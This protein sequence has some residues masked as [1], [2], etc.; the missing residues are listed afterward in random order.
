MPSSDAIQKMLQVDSAP[1]MDSPPKAGDASQTN[2]PSLTSCRMCALE[3]RTSCK[4]HGKSG[5]GG[6][7]PGAS[8]SST[9]SVAPTLDDGSLLLE[10]TLETVSLQLSA[11]P[12]DS[13]TPV[14]ENTDQLTLKPEVSLKDIEEELNE[15]IKT[16]SNE[17]NLDENT[18]LEKAEENLG[19]SYK[20]DDNKLTINFSDK[21]LAKR[22]I[23]KL[24]DNNLVY[25]PSESK[26]HTTQPEPGQHT[27]RPEADKE[28]H[29]SGAPNPYT[30]RLIPTPYK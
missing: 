19:I 20:Y 18:A 10:A 16:V 4:G 3:N 1:K 6:E 30:I 13:P 27:A 25:S 11:L 8:G 2:K 7:E 15:F 22:F 14:I 26:Q 23:E 12:T 29:I 5:G 28:N 17:L 21:N 24:V 9:D